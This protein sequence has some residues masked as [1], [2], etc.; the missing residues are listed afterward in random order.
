MLSNK[1]FL[2]FMAL[3][4]I[5]LLGLNSCNSKK[6][7][8][9]EVLY[10]QYCA[11]CHIVPKIDELPKDIWEN[12]ILPD[13]LSR[14]DIEEMYQ[15][16]ITA[17]SGF[18][19][20]IKLQDWLL[21][22]NYI[23]SL[24]PDK[25]PLTQLPNNSIIEQFHSKPLALD[26]QNGAFITY[27]ES[28]QQRLFFGDISSSLRSYNFNSNNITQHYQGKT[29]ITWF[30]HQ[31]SLEIVTEV[32][33]LDP[34]ELEQGKLF[35]KIS[36]D[37]LGLSI[38]FH[39]PVHTLVEDLNKDGKQE[40]VVSEFGDKTG[41]LSLLIKNDSMGYY[42][43]ELLNQPGCIRTIAKDM[44]KDGRTDLITLTSQ[45][46]ESITILY[47]EDN[48]KFRADKVLEFRSV[49]GSSWYELVDYNG[50]G[51]DDIITVNGDNADK[52]YVHKPYH[53]MRIHL[54]DGSNNFKETYF[55]PLNGA[56]RVLARDFD[57]D[58]DVD[59]GLI[60][61]FP[62]YEKAPELSFVYLENKDS[63]NYNFT[64]KVL[65]DPNA[66]RWFLMDAA[67]IDSDGDEDI[68]LSSFT[69]VFTPV[70]KDL[71]KRWSEN[72]V[73]ILILENKLN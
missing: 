39:R 4:A 11:S 69:Y 59:F 5:Y 19:P 26:D 29:P 36:G 45:A 63:K 32:G 52:S 67:D 55:Y 2:T 53:G 7:K 30:N 25:L 18:R 65:T 44:N 58:G 56:T 50:D 23:I 47:Q 38:K 13:M 31:E 40:L 70:P 34:S 15:N 57:Q 12:S 64:T 54:N 49:Y 46:M 21:L 33:I 61:T 68:I 51:F 60:S 41:S 22:K 66:G 10:N 73:D 43:K 28:D 9:E 24:A 14:M 72:N 62:D 1:N 35:S 71:S 16:P 48:L 6:Q 17:K 20:K 3:S 8:R 27:L 42:K 37:T